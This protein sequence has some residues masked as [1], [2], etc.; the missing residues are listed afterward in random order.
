MVRDNFA[1]FILSHGRADNMKTVDTLRKCNYTGK[2][3]I[4]LDNEDKTYN[5]YAEKFGEDKL[6][7]FDKLK[8][9]QEF[10]TC[11][12]SYRDRKAIV[13]ARN[14]CFNIAQDL[15]LT[16]FLELDDDYTCFRQRWLKGNTFAS[17]YVTQL[18]PIIEATLDFL[19]ESG[20]LTVA[21]AQTGDFLGGKTS[22]VYR[23]RLTRKAMNS[24]FCRTDRRFDFIGRINEDVN[25]YTWRGTRGELMFT[26]TDMSLDQLATQQNGGGMS[27]LY[28]NVGTY[29]KSI[30]SIIV[31]PSCV[32][33]AE[34]GASHKRIHH[35]VDW[36]TCTPKILNERF[37]K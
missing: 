34:M 22:R 28:L 12:V 37:K 30:Y 23:E 26:I 13:Y 32:K 5:R 6:I 14:A 24:F 15:G 11:D 36:E 3:Y 7:V 1:I 2:W 9:S 21:W 10:D 20:A 27:D 4:V 17:T 25:T 19:D 31:S 33:I 35:L 16:Y 29:I 8:I 18:D